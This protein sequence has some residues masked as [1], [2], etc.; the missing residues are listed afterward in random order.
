[1][2][3]AICKQGQTRP[4]N[5]TVT[6][7]RG[8]LILVVKAVPAQVCDVCGESYL[9]EATTELLLDQVGEASNA[10]IQI[11]VRTYVAA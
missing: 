1:M 5:V 9:D 4:G 3:C 11:E 6:L 2:I 8:D 7:E 10:G